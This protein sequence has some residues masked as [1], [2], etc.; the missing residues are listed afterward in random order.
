MVNTKYPEEKSELIEMLERDIDRKSK[1]PTA[2]DLRPQRNNDNFDWSVAYNKIR[3][4]FKDVN[5]AVWLTG[6][7]P[8]NRK[9]TEFN[10]TDTE[11]VEHELRT[12]EHELGR[13]PT[14]TEMQEDNPYITINMIKKRFG[15]LQQ[16]V[17]DSGIPYPTQIIQGEGVFKPE[18]QND[19]VDKLFREEKDPEQITEYGDTKIEAVID[20]Y[21]PWVDF[22]ADRI[23]NT[24]EEDELDELMNYKRSGE[25]FKYIGE[26]KHQLTEV[27][28]E[29]GIARPSVE[30]Y[31]KELEEKDLVEN[32]LGYSLT[33]RGQKIYDQ[34]F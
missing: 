12:L 22:S 31:V 26:G 2:T 7:E 30:D 20:T 11:L 28:N 16:I 3:R 23:D 17:M 24:F 19:I 33:E 10:G 4:E 34:I 5:N 15:E 32:N 29:I 14:L 9:L 13:P 1:V 27:A 8:E 18:E 6:N 21:S 25:V